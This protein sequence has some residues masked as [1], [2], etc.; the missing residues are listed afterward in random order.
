MGD[1]KLYILD[2]G[3]RFEQADQPIAVDEQFALFNLRGGEEIEIGDRDFFPVM[4]Y[5]WS[6][7]KWFSIRHKCYLQDKS[8]FGEAIFHKIYI[9]G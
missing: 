8:G 6:R 1:I 9:P 5:R 3:V 4:G 2:V 7:G